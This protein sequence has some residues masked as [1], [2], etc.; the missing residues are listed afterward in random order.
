MESGELYI[1]AFRAAGISSTVLPNR[2]YCTSPMPLPAREL[3]T[4]LN[5]RDRVAR[6][7]GL[8]TTFREGNS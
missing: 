8:K 4:L 6:V 2:P 1:L 3:H 5:M 7:P